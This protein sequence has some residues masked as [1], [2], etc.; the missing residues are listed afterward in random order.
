MTTVLVERSFAEPQVFREIQAQEDAKSWCLEMHDVT[1]SYT[2][3]GADGRRMVCVYTAPDAESVR[4][5]Q[6]KADLPFDRVWAAAEF[7]LVR[8]PAHDPLVTLLMIERTYPQATTLEAVLRMRAGSAW[9][10]ETNNVQA[11]SSY[12]QAGGSRGL[13]VCVAPGIESVRRASKSANMPLD[14][15]WPAALEISGK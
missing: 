1:F 7:S 6:Q 9:C 10:L 3:F 4:L 14:R 11:V 12:Y 13:C 15:V 8:T 2:Y 5:A